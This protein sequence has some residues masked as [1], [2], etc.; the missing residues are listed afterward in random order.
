MQDIIANQLAL[1]Q[2]FFLSQTTFDVKQRINWLKTF[3]NAIKQHQD[4]LLAALKQDLNR[5]IAIGFLTEV[6]IVYH[7]LDTFIKHLKCWSKDSYVPPILLLFHKKA[8]IIH[9]PHG[10]VYLIVPFNFPILLSLQPLVASIG[11]GNVT[12]VKMP[13]LT[14]NVNKVVQKI[15]SYLPNELVS[16]LPNNLT[17]DDRHDLNYYPWDFIFFTGSK[18]TAAKIYACQYNRFIPTVFELGGKSPMIVDDTCD[19]KLAVHKYLNT[20]LINAGQICVAA[21]YLILK[22]NIVQEFTNLLVN[23]YHKE[24]QN[25]N[26]YTGKLIS[27]NKIDEVQH[28]IDKQ[29]QQ[30]FILLN[31]QTVDNLKQL[32]FCFI[33]YSKCQ[34]KQY[35]ENEL[36]SPIGYYYTY[37]DIGD[38]TKIVKS[39]DNPLVLYC[40]SKDKS[41][42]N[43]CKHY[44]ASGAMV[45]NDTLVH[46]FHGNLP[47][48]GVKD[49]GLG[50][51]HGK[52]S[53]LT[54]SHNEPYLYSKWYGDKIIDENKLFDENFFLTK[55]LMNKK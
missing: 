55:H 5:S 29:N 35:L 4:E 51:Y 38:L 22:E 3:K 46:V 23:I 21:D 27:Q 25:S 36:F 30:D 39:H 19:L 52:Y 53:F 48:G 37:H 42:I 33:P 7:E 2:K 41:L 34:D 43:F 24:Y 13:T 32:Q 20:K 14:P 26:I 12:V 8:R 16:V 47:F 49:S 50:K 1:H 54:F 6:Q 9:S 17:Q 28:W 44:F 11:C 15:L 45:V 18:N 10:I 40:F 31:Y